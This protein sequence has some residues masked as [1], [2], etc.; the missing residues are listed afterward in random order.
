MGVPRFRL[1]REV[2]MACGGFGWPP[3]K[4]ETTQLQTQE[5]TRKAK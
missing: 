4:T 2:K 5:E 3:K 1:D